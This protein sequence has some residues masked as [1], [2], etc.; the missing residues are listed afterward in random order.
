MK[1]KPWASPQVQM[2]TLGRH[3]WSV[4]RLFELAR[5]LPVMEVPLNHLNL[6]YTYEKLTLREMVMHMKAVHDA[7]LSKP[8][9]LDE[10]GELMDGRHR[11][12][13][14]ML[15]GAVTIKVVRFEENPEPCQVSD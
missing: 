5:A 3:T 11:L 10:D 1:I 12:M 6:Y 13:K 15:A 14:A 4:P 2:C 9:I 7:D 8:I